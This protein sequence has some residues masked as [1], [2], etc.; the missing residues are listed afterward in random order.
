MITTRPSEQ[1]KDDLPLNKAVLTLQS[2]FFNKHHRYTGVEFDQDLKGLQ[3]AQQNEIAAGN[4]D[5]IVKRCLKFC[6]LRQDKFI[7][8]KLAFTLFSGIT[9]PNESYSKPF[10]KYSKILKHLLY[11]NFKDI[12]L[13]SRVVDD[14]YTAWKEECN[15]KFLTRKQIVSYDKKDILDYLRQSAQ[16]FMRD[17]TQVNLIK[18][19][20]ADDPSE[21]QE[22]VSFKDDVEEINYDFTHKILQL[23]QKYIPASSEI[24]QSFTQITTKIENLLQKENLSEEVL[25]ELKEE[26]IK[27]WQAT[28]RYVISKE[29]DFGIVPLTTPSFSSRKIKLT[30]THG[31]GLFFFGQFLFGKNKGYQTDSEEGGLGIYIAPYQAM[32]YEEYYAERAAERHFDIPVSANFTIESQYLQSTVR[33]SDEAILCHTNRKKIELH[34]IKQLT[35][36]KSYFRLEEKDISVY[37]N[38]PLFFQKLFTTIFL[39]PETRN[40]PVSPRK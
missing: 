8:H 19:F 36:E 11:K 4:Y 18:L 31:G 16:S 13:I 22:D 35:Y 14:A 39:E 40:Q 12:N 29:N 24:L 38:D 26:T 2:C 15:Q 21:P 33:H 6:R 17:F 37:E 10:L 7:L 27:V 32:S 30:P 23:L 34:G 28:W 5:I 3:K 9:L 20:T 25:S 1:K